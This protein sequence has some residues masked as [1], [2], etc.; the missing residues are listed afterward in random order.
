MSTLDC[1]DELLCGTPFEDGLTTTIGAECSSQAGF[2]RMEVRLYQSCDKRDS[3]IPTW[4]PGS[5]QESDCYFESPKLFG[6][7]KF[8]LT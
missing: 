5:I 3:L 2:W 4:P 8:P 6:S 7:R 1:C